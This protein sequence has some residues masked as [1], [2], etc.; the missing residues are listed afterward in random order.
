MSIGSQRDF[1]TF[2]H[3][4]RLAT[5][6][7]LFPVVVTGDETTEKLSAGPVVLAGA[8]RVDTGARDV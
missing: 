1:V 5:V 2:D 3:R 4:C 7:R 6:G 8:R